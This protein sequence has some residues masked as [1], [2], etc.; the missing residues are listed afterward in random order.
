MRWRLMSLLFL[1]MSGWAASAAVG[2]AEAVPTVKIAVVGSFAKTIT[3]AQFQVMATTFSA[4]LQAQAGMKGQLVAGGSP[5][6]ICKQLAD[7]SLHFAVFHGIEYGWMKQKHPDLEPVMLNILNP[8]WLRPTIVVAKDAPAKAFA[9]CKGQRLA[10]V[11]PAREDTRLYLHRL[12]SQ[13]GGRADD[14]FP[15]YKV[16]PSIEGA[17]DD[18]VDGDF[19]VVVL[20]QSG[21]TMYQRLKPARYAKIR[22]LEQADPFP[23]SC[24]VYRRSTIPDATI[25][26]FRAGMS[27]AHQSVM[28]GHL[29]ALMKI[30][31]FEAPTEDYHKQ[32]AEAVKSYPALDPHNLVNSTIGNAAK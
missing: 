25:Q 29:M 15:D 5:D 6:E 28:G 18:L 1:A 10:I 31:R 7:G 20:E 26:T 30:R 23:T 21:L 14:L 27:T 8:E 19:Q 2:D 24:I 9:D 13:I 12:C 22:I 4:V 17:L 3:P 32:L 11:K 16:P